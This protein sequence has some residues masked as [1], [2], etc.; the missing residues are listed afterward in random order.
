ML[1]LSAKIRKTQG[2]KTKALRIKGV[3]PAVL[4]GP[5]IKTASLEVDAKEFQKVYQETGEST[6][7]SLEIESGKKKYLVLIH[8]L[9]RDPL[10]SEVIHVDLYQPSLEKEIEAHVPIILEGESPAI[11]N[12]GGTL[13]KNIGEVVVKALPQNL[14]KEIKVNISGLATF[15]NHLLIKDL[16]LAEGIKILKEPDEIVASIAQPE[17]VEEE[18]EKPIEEKV[19]EV[20]KVEKEKKEEA[21]EVEEEKPT[22]TAGKEEKKGK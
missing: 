15:G 13:I 17:K 7:I 18:L 2:R 19:E 14:P 16:K 3:L 8:D 1:S 12:L 21:E 6:L 5:E 22:E 4:Y 11:K 9:K 10:T 20:E